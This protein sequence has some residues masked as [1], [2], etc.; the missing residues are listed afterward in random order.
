MSSVETGRVEVFA[1][2]PLLPGKT[3]FQP[4]RPL[5]QWKSA[6]VTRRLD[7]VAGEFV[8]DLAPGGPLPLTRGWRVAIDL[9][10]EQ[11]LEGYVDSVQVA[12]GEGATRVTFL[13][14]DLTG[15]LVDS[16]PD[17]E[18]VE[19]RNLWLD[20]LLTVLV[21]K[22]LR[23]VFDQNHLRSLGGEIPLFRLNQGE[24]YHRAIERAC[25]M[26]GALAYS[27]PQGEIA[28]APP[29]GALL[30]RP[31]FERNAF[32]VRVA[33]NNL[34]KPT[35]RTQL[36][37]PDGADLVWG[38]NLLSYRIEVSDAD[39]FRTYIVKGQ[40]G[41]MDVELGLAAWQ[42][43]G[44]A[45]D[46]GIRDGRTLVVVAETNAWGEDAQARAE[47]EAAWRAAQSAKI[48]AE[49][50]GWRRAPGKP[51]WA[52]NELVRV[53]IP[54]LDLSPFIPRDPN[55]AARSVL[56]SQFVRSAPQ[57]A[58]PTLLVNAITFQRAPAG[59]GGT[60]TSL[61]LVRRD[62]Y[63]RRAEVDQEPQ[64]ESEEAFS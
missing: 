21:P 64:F 24:S 19:W 46:L 40:A 41:G 36:T 4:L 34:L 7:A 63:V 52:V 42:P 12:Q 6:R 57:R 50:A 11:V 18:A 44:R 61:E 29:F 3:S 5:T 56:S 35:L 26:R 55:L 60:T 45:V 62:A 2:P 30:E 37:A 58:A 51:L 22:D 39:R 9:D 48:S 16:S 43:E 10:G 20:E 28:I 14:R 54:G 8:L 13:G 49:V 15:D 31:R 53:V 32:G 27:L 17:S 33:R 23:L 38:E 47:W 1:R 59:S 25:R